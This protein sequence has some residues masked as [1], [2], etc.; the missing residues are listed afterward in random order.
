MGICVND[1]VHLAESVLG[2]ELERS[3]DHVRY[4]LKINSRIIGRFKYS[5]S[6]RG[7]YQINEYILRMQA[8]SMQCSAQTWKLLLQ[9][10][11]TRRDYFQELLNNGLI[12]KEEFLLLTSL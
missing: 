12:N 8:K 11:L 1:L 6:W 9:G 2:C 3:K 4:V 5:H 10:K 7:S